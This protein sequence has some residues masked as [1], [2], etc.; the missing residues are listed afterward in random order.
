MANNP[1]ANL[2][3]ELKS[4]LQFE[5]ETA[6]PNQI[7]E[8]ISKEPESAGKALINQTD[9]FNLFPQLHYDKARHSELIK[10]E[11]NAQQKAIEVA[12]QLGYMSGNEPP[13]K[14]QEIISKA[15]SMISSFH[16]EA[17][18]LGIAP[19]ESPDEEPKGPEIP[20]TPFELQQE[21]QAEGKLPPLQTKVE[22]GKTNIAPPTV[23]RPED[24]LEVERAKTKTERGRLQG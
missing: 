2:P 16:S 13:E 4:E 15:Q 22:P 3:E 19:P 21:K 6:L 20:K 18:K 24:S 7:R 12:K 5:T 10:K 14:Q 17:E 1:V 11:Q 23:K 9:T 8:T